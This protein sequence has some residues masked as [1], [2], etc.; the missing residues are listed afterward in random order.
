MS[1]GRYCRQDQLWAR[2]AHN[3]V[4]LTRLDYIREEAFFAPQ[5]A[6]GY[7]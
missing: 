5:M 4:H 3:R 2:T 6:F 1:I 7:L